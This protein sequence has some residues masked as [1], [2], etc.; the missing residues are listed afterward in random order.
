MI[1]GIFVKRAEHFFVYDND[2]SSQP[3]AFRSETCGTSV[4]AFDQPSQLA[5]IARRCELL[6]FPEFGACVALCVYLVFE[7]H[8]D[9]VQPGPSWGRSL[10]INGTAITRGPVFLHRPDTMACPGGHFPVLENHQ[11]LPLAVECPVRSYNGPI[12]ARFLYVCAQY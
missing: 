7:Y 8:R 5:L 12:G 11:P 6:P 10:I 4:S 2:S 3:W 1:R 9:L